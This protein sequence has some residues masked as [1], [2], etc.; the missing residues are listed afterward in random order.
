MHPVTQDADDAK[1]LIEKEGSEGLS[2][3]CDLAQGEETCK[4]IVDQVGGS[5]LRWL[6]L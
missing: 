2:I 5:S 6:V 4:Q 1:T 3:P